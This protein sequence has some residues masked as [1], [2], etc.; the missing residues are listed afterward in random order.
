[1]PPGMY[2]LDGQLV[3]RRFAPVLPAHVTCRLGHSIKIRG[4][5]LHATPQCDYHWR[6][7]D[8]RCQAHVWLYR[9]T[10]RYYWLLDVTE[11]EAD[12]I[13]R[14]QMDADDVLAHFGLGI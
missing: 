5:P 13:H 14:R 1:M 6:P 2:R 11:A 10:P 4:R 12:A 3:V 7:G 8:Q 9:I